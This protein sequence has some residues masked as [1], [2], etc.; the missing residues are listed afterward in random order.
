MSYFTTMNLP[1][2]AHGKFLDLLKHYEDRP[3]AAVLDFEA[4]LRRFFDVPAVCTWSNC[5]TSIALALRHAAAG[6]APRVVVAGLAYRRTADIVLWAGLEPVFVDNSAHDLALDL[7]ALRR[8]LSREPVGCILAQHPMVHL[9]D[10]EALCALA[11]EFQVPVVFDSVEATGASYR[12]HRLGRFGVAEAFSLHPSK[13]IN[14]AEGG[15]LTFGDEAQH[16]RFGKSMSDLGLWDASTGR[17][18]MFQLEPLHAVM[19]LASVSIYE[20]VRDRHRS[21]FERYREGLADSRGLGLVQY[22]AE[23]DPNYKSVLV[24]ILNPSPAFRSRLMSHLESRRIGA[25]AYYA[26]LHPLTQSAQLPAARALA[27]QYMILPI[28]HSVSL[29][30][31]DS[32]CACIADFEQQS[33]SESTG[34][35]HA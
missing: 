16:R 11:D 8:T 1:A 22:D 34:G 33:E 9:L 30:D 17:P 32:I 7:S 3:Q 27:E 21:H 18:S 15:V 19:G 4:A 29:T 31:I 13:V 28:G 20:E 25:R 24:Q 26:P 14:A 6:R 2:P 35:V 5:F 12:G 10:I 23:T